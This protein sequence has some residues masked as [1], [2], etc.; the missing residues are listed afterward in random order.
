MKN[1]SLTPTQKKA[2]S[3]LLAVDGSNEVYFC[4]DLMTGKSYFSALYAITVCTSKEHARVVIN[5]E[6][7][8]TLMLILN[9]DP[10]T[11]F[12]TDGNIITIKKTQS[13]IYLA[14]YIQYES[15]IN[16]DRFAAFKP[17]AVIIDNRSL[18]PTDVVKVLY[19]RLNFGGK[20]LTT[21]RKKSD[22]FFVSKSNSIFEHK[23]TDNIYVDNSYLM[24][25]KPRTEAILRKRKGKT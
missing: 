25:K 12:M 9:K 10:K 7:R 3:E 24:S 22:A 18:Y 6:L 4:G 19:F 15:D 20:L 21:G 13:I 14:D 5:L 16:Y 17:D 23:L 8:K 1:I 2:M 11:E